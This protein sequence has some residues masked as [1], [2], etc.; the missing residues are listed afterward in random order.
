MS[1]IALFRI[2]YIY[3]K[4]K[5]IFANV[6]YPLCIIGRGCELAVK[7]P[8]S[9]CLQGPT[10][11][12]LFEWRPSLLILAAKPH[13]KGGDSSAFQGFSLFVKP[14]SCSNHGYLKLG[15]K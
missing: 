12:T 15:E 13:V 5:L 2:K 6:D 3:L 11:Y 4:V 1:C 14:A 8:G 7:S 9:N 10:H